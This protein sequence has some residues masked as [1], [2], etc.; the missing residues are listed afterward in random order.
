MFRPL[1]SCLTLLLSVPVVIASPALAHSHGGHHATAEI[2][3]AQGRV[4]GTAHLSQHKDGIHVDV[5][6]VGLPA[7]VH[8][9]HIHTVGACT[10][11]DFTSAGGHWNPGHKQHGAENPAGAHMGDMP[12]MT[13]G[14]D[15]AGKLSAV[16]KGAALS[17][18]DMPLFDA[19]GAAVVI[20]AAADDYKTDPTGN[21]GARLGCGV[22]KAK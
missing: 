16:I 22:L 15:G 19:D 20:H 1:Y 13:I 5:K 14:G 11:P 17:G 21:A 2:L 10:A 4:S 6:A 8:A 18:G 9:V 12:N 3:D 7:G